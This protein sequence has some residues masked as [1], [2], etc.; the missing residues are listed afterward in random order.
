MAAS[1]AAQSTVRPGALGATTGAPSTIEI[2]AFDRCGL[3]RLDRR[4]VRARAA[5]RR[6]RST[7]KPSAASGVIVV[8]AAIRVH[9][10]LDRRHRRPVSTS[11]ADRI[12]VAS[13]A[14]ACTFSG[15]AR[16]GASVT[17]STSPDSAPGRRPIQARMT[18]STDA[19]T[20]RLRPITG[21]TVRT[22]TS[23]DGAPRPRPARRRSSAA[24]P[25]RRRSARPRRPGRPAARS[26][27]GEERGQPDERVRRAGAGRLRRCAAT[28]ASA[29][30]RPG[31]SA[32]G[33][34][35][36]STVIGCRV[37]RARP[38]AVSAGEACS[39]VI[40]PT[41]TPA[42]VVFRSISPLVRQQVDQV[43]H[44]QHEDSP[45]A[46]TSAMIRCGRAIQHAPD[47]DGSARPAG[48]VDGPAGVETTGASASA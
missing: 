46:T 8:A 10:D 39:G 12:A 38:A 41:S 43:H 37:R 13:A 29:R 11:G 19:G 3:R 15:V 47:A 33:S 31:R 6:R 16:T 17:G 21:C 44:G 5:R 28:S 22:G 20:S 40:P 26:V 32:T 7:T 45:P 35:C 25:G 14:A 36:T 24:T 4:G 1:V 27:L 18:A 9:R 23:V 2:V 30:P 48:G 34:P 42:M